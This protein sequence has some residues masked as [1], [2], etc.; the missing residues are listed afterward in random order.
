MATN[1]AVSSPLAT[2]PS[3]DSSPG[4][5]FRPKVHR[6]RVALS[7][8]VCRHR[9]VKCDRGRPFCRACEKYHVAHLCTYEQ[10]GWANSDGEKVE[11]IMG[12]V[13]RQRT[14]GNV[15]VSPVPLESSFLKAATG[16]SNEGKGYP[17]P[18][19]SS[20]SH[21]GIGM[22]LAS[23]SGSQVESP[24]VGIP[25]ISTTRGSASGSAPRPR[26]EL[27]ASS[28]Q[29]DSSVLSELHALKEKI[30]QL[31]ASVSTDS[32]SS[33]LPPPTSDQLSKPFPTASAAAEVAK[34]V[35]PPILS[36]GLPIPDS[37]KY[38]LPPIGPRSSF[39]SPQS[40]YIASGIP[41]QYRTSFSGL[42]PLHQESPAP[43]IPPIPAL[44][45]IHQNS[46]YD[47]YGV[48]PE[49]RVDFFKEASA[50]PGT[51]SRIN[52]HGPLCWVSMILKDP[53]SRPIIEKIISL[54]KKMGFM[55]CG[56]IQKM[57][58]GL[59]NNV[60]DEGLEC[61]EVAE[62]L[63][64]QKEGKGEEPAD[65]FIDDKSRDIG[66]INLETLIDDKD[67]QSPVAVDGEV[68]SAVDNRKDDEDEEKVID[69]PVRADREMQLPE[70]QMCNDEQLPDSQP[71]QTA[72]STKR[73]AEVITISRI[74]KVLPNRKTIWLLI[75]RFFK[76][77]YPFLPYLDE[78]QFVAEVERILGARSDS[79][80]RITS[81]RIAKKLDFAIMGSLL[82][83]L[84]LASLSLTGN[85]DTEP[86][87]PL[88]TEDEVY[89]I[90][91]TLASE[92]INVAQLCLNQFKLL[93]RC[94][95]RI[96]QCAIL[97]RD[98]QRIDGSD[99]F[100]DG[101]SQIFTGMLIQMGISIGLNRDPSQFD[102]A[103]NK[104]RMGALWRKIWYRLMT[105]DT[106]QSSQ[107]GDPRVIREDFYDTE[108]PE[109]S[110]I[111]SNN[112]DLALEQETLRCMRERYEL[113]QY[114]C[115]L[116]S[117]V[118]NVK[119]TP[120]VS[121]VLKQVESLE[122]FIKLR[123]NSLASILTPADGDHV[124]NV[125]KV[126]QI[127]SYCE[128]VSLLHPCYHH[129][130]LFY[131][132]TSNAKACKHFFRKSLMLLME[133]VGNFLELVK[134]SYRFV[135]PGFDFCLTPMLELFMH[136]TLH[137]QFTLILRIQE[138]QRQLEMSSRPDNSLLMFLSEFGQSI[139]TKNI[140]ENYMP[141]L[142]VLAKRYFYAWRMMK[143][144]TFII[145]M[146]KDKSLG[147]GESSAPYNF[148]VDMTPSEIHELSDVANPD[149]YKAGMKA[150]IDSSR[151]DSEATGFDVDAPTSSSASSSGFYSNNSTSPDTDLD[152]FWSEMF[153]KNDGG[154]L[155]LERV[156]SEF[157]GFDDTSFSPF[158]ENRKANGFWEEK[159]SRD[160]TPRDQLVDRAILGM[161]VP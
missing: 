158:E 153:Y 127:L 38:S 74:I 59:A 49:D 140:K 122:S 113:E 123:W 143:A 112:H 80:E 151:R 61:C 2:S 93:R 131:Q 7:C 71:D 5:S 72:L 21:I 109:F 47:R 69:S 161:Y 75:D 135:G 46:F 126:H 144:H 79:E 136:K 8:S 58:K 57:T 83:A 138:Y 37:R 159:K 156:F 146:L 114:M 89:L 65:N 137:I 48:D 10:P 92:T 34:P 14:D 40:P 60:R 81:I 148:L 104:N 111:S 44:T 51:Y 157:T 11:F 99:G 31:E 110:S 1:S 107:M 103:V 35:F 118:L 50:N 106:S 116:A 20:S 145:Q 4:S 76:Y 82:I 36:H 119:E 9:K 67:V 41:P 102:S 62:A 17:P 139:L 98:Y 130:L 39:Y 25:A 91:H 15:D 43:S 24:Q 101:D 125:R 63:L 94:T 30:R 86:E 152:K 18:V 64:R 124:H 28:R 54:K 66:K 70:E 53:Y 6:H 95:L 16:G 149:R 155:N 73:E 120:A 19:N 33:T 32:L 52:S 121:D 77:V 22:S 160:G 68:K 84:R 27:A 97:M 12:T 128:A 42:S 142:S 105:I 129:L 87:F 150:K 154:D 141:A 133:V 85:C 132:S 56:A 26:L 3:S 96:F 134:H 90:N 88:R 117:L 13:K 45:P 29:S 78:T 55:P 108:L 23:R 100:S 147:F 115:K